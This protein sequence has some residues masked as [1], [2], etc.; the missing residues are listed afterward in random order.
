MTYLFSSNNIITNEVEVKNDAGNALPVVGVEGSPLTVNFSG[1]SVDSFGRLRMSTPYTVFDNSFNIDEK[2]RVWDTLT[3]S[4]GAINFQANIA[5]VEMGITTAAGSKVVRQTK[6]YFQYQPGKSLLS[7]NTFVMN[8]AKANLR[9]R[10]GYF[11]SKNG[12]FLERDGDTAYIVKRSY[13]TGSAVDTRISQLNWN[14]DTLLGS[15][16]SEEHTSE[17]QSH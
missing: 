13:V 12:V 4:S 3:A 10:V 1:V 11:D 6:Q 7:M 15:G 8:P 16:R 17:L 9:Q 14:Q 5:A 2:T